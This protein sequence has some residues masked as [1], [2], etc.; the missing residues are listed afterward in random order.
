MS[1]DKQNPEVATAPPADKETSTG[2][3]APDPTFGFRSRNAARAVR[4]LAMEP[5]VPPE[6]P[7]GPGPAEVVRMIAP[8]IAGSHGAPDVPP[9]PPSP[10]PAPPPEVAVRG[11]SRI[12]PHE[13]MPLP[14]QHVEWDQ[15][16]RAEIPRYV[17]EQLRE[18]MHRHRLTSISLLMRLIQQF[19]GEDREAP[20]YVRPEDM[21]GDRRKLPRRR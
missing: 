20:F 9:L 14:G 8:R 10:P 17:N 6:A 1:D 5:S 12:A 18:Y 21:V 7:P 4:P 16:F 13:V 3:P 19:K 15:N 2:A 11:Q